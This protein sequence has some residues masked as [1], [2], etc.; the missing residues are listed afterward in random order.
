MQGRVPG[1]VTQ[2]LHQY[3]TIG[4]KETVDAAVRTSINPL[5][6]PR[7]YRLVGPGRHSFKVETGDRSPVGVPR[8]VEVAE[9]ASWAVTPTQRFESAPH[10]EG[11]AEQRCGGLQPRT[12]RCKSC[13]PLHLNRCG[14]AVQHSQRFTAI[15]GKAATRAAARFLGVT[16]PG[17]SSCLGRRMP[18]VRIQPS[19]PIQSAV[20]RTEERPP[21]TRKA[22]GSIPPGATTLRL[23][24]LRL[25][26]Q[27]RRCQRQ[28]PGA[29]P[30]RSS[31]ALQ[32]LTVMHRLC[33]PENGDRYLGWAPTITG[34]TTVVRFMPRREATIE[35]RRY[36]TSRLQADP[37]VSVRGNAHQ[38]AKP[39]PDFGTL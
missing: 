5:V 25:L 2:Y 12:H 23:Q 1:S 14:A 36:S 11:M 3:P 16:Q 34:S 6:A 38:S 7:S 27:S 28:A 17:Q 35:A 19:R 15:A 37:G 9:A 22:G 31:N 21:D 20:A 18:L 10:P 32:A 26:V 4:R 13:C 24:V 33:N 29:I 39:G 8:N 30:G